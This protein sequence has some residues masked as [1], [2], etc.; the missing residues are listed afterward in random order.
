VKR[1]NGGM[2]EEANGHPRLFFEVVVECQR[3]S[4]KKR[5]LKKKRKKKSWGPDWE[6]DS[7]GWLPSSSVALKQGGEKT[8]RR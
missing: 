8:R 3:E 4:K 2:K 5:G 1:R 6:D 7:M